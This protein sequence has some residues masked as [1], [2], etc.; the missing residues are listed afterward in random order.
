M[1]RCFS[2]PLLGKLENYFADNGGCVKKIEKY[3]YGSQGIAK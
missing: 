1:Q 2:C 3:I